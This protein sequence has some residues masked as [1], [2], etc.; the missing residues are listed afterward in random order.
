MGKFNDGDMVYSIQDGV[1]VVDEVRSIHPYPVRVRDTDYTACGRL[2]HSDVNPVLLTLAEARAKGY[3]V[4]KVTRKVTK[5]VSRWANVYGSAGLTGCFHETRE[6]ADA[7]VTSSVR[8]ACVELT[9]TYEVE[10]VE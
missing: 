2:F 6:E 1:V 5:T 4:P 7:N 3:D 8:T 10:E 9:G